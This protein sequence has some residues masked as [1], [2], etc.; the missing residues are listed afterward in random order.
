MSRKI[1]QIIDLGSKVRGAYVYKNINFQIHSGEIVGLLGHNGAGKTTMLKNIANLEIPQIG[2]VKI[3]N[4][5]N[6]INEVNK[7][8]IMVSDTIELINNMTIHENFNLFSHN[9]SYNEQFYKK[10]LSIFNLT[11]NEKIR[12]LSKGNKEIVQL[13]IFLSL[14][15]DLY[16]LDEPLAAI[17]IFKRDEIYNMLIEVSLQDKAILITTHLISDIQ[18]I[19]SRVLYLNNSKIIFDKS[20]EEIQSQSETLVEYIKEQIEKEVI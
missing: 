17:D 8:V 2:K 9:Y 14:E 1:L 15:V 4:R 19:L 16:V 13:I 11:G 7:N 3:N 10:Y 12:S 5:V 20:I 18:N 6:N